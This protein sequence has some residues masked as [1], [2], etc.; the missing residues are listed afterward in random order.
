M[1]SILDESLVKPFVRLFL[2]FNRW[3]RAWTR[4]LSGS[5]QQIN[6]TRDD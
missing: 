4:W 1:D 5:E 2:T 3:E 6:G